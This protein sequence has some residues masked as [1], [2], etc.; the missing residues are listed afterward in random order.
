MNKVELVTALAEEADLSRAK[1]AQMVETMLE[2]IGR[3]LCAGEEVRLSGFGTFVTATR[4]AAK[5]RNPRTGEPMDLP[6]S[7]SVRFKVARGLK[8]ALDARP[9]GRGEGG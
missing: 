1:T 9:Q 2:M 6:S 3:T 5:G 4:K 8:D 7:V